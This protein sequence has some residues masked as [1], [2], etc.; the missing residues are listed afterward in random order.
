M[1]WDGSAWTGYNTTTT[2]YMVINL[3]NGKKYAFAVKAYANGVYGETSEIVYATPVASIIPAGVKAGAGDAKV[4]VKWNAVTG[5]SSYRVM[6]W[7][8]AKWTGY[9]TTATSYM[10]RNLTNGKKYAF[11]VKAYINGAYSANS[12]TV[13]A[14]PNA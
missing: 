3:T 2:S 14:T 5:A 6:V 11:V 9:N 8:G 1:V 13:Y 12:T 10:V 7:D 4:Q